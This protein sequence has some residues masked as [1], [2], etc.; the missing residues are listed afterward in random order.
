L[1]PW[2]GEIASMTTKYYINIKFEKLSKVTVIGDATMLHPS[3]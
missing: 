3:I 2:T 1:L